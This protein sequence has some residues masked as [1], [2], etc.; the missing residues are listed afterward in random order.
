MNRKNLVLPAVIGLLA[1][2]LAA[3]GSESGG[4][5]DAIVVGTTDR[6]SATSSAPAPLDPAT[7]YDTGSWNILRQTVQTLM[8]AP[9][10]GGEPVPDAADRCEFTDSENESYRCTLRP[11]LS[12]ADGDRVTPEDV[13]YSIDRVRT[14]DDDNGAKGLLAN[15]D[16]VEPRGGREVVF[17]LKSPDATFPYKLATPVAGIVPP[18]HYAKDR[19]RE[20]FA[21]N[22]SGPYTLKAETD[23]EGSLQRAVFTRNP[24]YKGELKV[25]NER[26][27]LR[28][29]RDA[30]S[31]GD[32]LESGD[33]DLMNRTM[34][35]RQTERLQSSPPDGVDLVE[36]P[37][38]EIRYLGFNTEAP[39]V[40][41]RAVRQAV[42]QLVD[43]GQIAEEVYGGS[44]EPL[45]SLVPTFITGH[46]TSFFDAYGNP[47]TAKAAKLLKDAGIDTP[48]PLTL[49]YTTDHYG[50]ATAKEFEVLQK[51]LN[52]SGLF[53]ASIKGGKWQDYRKAQLDGE[54]AVYGMGWF[55][56]F[57]DADNFV[58]PFLEKDNFLNSSYTNDTV[59][60]ELIPASRR[61]ADRTA[62][63]ASFEQAQD[64]VARDV[65]VL[66]LWQG[67]QFVAARDDITGVEWALSSTSELQLWELGR[68][69]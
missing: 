13:K 39:Q 48:V 33:I 16:T 64:I 53:D 68:G 62:A 58:A 37:G 50:P 15:I 19:L 26:V 60:D 17:H 34:T 24:S 7:A 45:Y 20:G 21:V 61:E 47:D 32:A 6:F 46:A 38:L 42:A 2:V 36:M 35:P 44:A 18:R 12:F 30:Q 25:R 22:G 31:M 51:Q 41:S 59:R 49:H 52:A 56:D 4:G 67:K 23:G 8:S 69:V 29:Y 55:P 1:P 66:P 54:Y 28:S 10:G 65:P 40:R 57:P 9:R 3:C 11:G 14:I 43:R 27:E 63:A 5:G